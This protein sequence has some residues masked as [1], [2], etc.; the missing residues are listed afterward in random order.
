MRTFG[1]AVLAFGL[2]AA[3]SAPAW[4]QGGRGFGGFGGG[5]AL[6]SNKGVQ[7]ELKVTDDQASK[8]NALAEEQRTKGQELRAKLQDLSQEDRQA[9]MQ[10]YQQTTQAE[11]QKSL[12]TILKPEQLKR[13]NQIQT[14]TAGINAFATPRVQEVMKLT[15]DQRSKIR[16]INQELMES[17][18]GQ[19]QGL[20]NASADERQAVM[21]KLADNRKAA[22][23]KVHALL[24]ADQK[25]AWKEL[26]GEPYEVKFEPR[27]NN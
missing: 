17:S 16:E 15:D 14:Q 25:A 8:L 18:R 11:I 1:K 13:Y 7:Q 2:V 6:L 21:K 23:D 10:E 26:T 12:G 20:Q 9:K 4:A 24:S 3:M 5:G 27:Q 19:F 22:L